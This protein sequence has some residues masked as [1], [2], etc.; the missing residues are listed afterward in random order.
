MTKQKHKFY[1]G[2]LDYYSLLFVFHDV[3]SQNTLAGVVSRL[4]FSMAAEST[5]EAVEDEEKNV[6]IC[7]QNSNTGRNEW[8]SFEEE[9]EVP[10]LP[11]PPSQG[12]KMSTEKYIDRLGILT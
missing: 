5:E 11:Q 7:A 9:C 1:T 8:V 12:N 10:L 6:E 3:P 4:V 2:I